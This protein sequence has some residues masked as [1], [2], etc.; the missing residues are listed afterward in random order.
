MEP[1]EVRENAIFV[2]KH[3]RSPSCQDDLLS[4]S[5]T[6]AGLLSVPSRRV[7]AS[8]GGVPAIGVVGE[9]GTT[10]PL[11]GFD[12]VAT[13]DFELCGPFA[14]SDSWRGST[15][16]AFEGSDAA[17]WSA[18]FTGCSPSLARLAGV[19]AVSL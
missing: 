5:T 12:G 18:G 7:C 10:L 6:T 1:I 15:A 16:V 2:L 13:Y 11:S 19:S 4:L 3:L 17:F 8:D 9:E 14:D